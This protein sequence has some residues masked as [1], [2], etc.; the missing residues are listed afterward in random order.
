MY[1]KA[2]I[3]PWYVTR[4][5]VDRVA[6]HLRRV[7]RE[8]LRRARFDEARD[9]AADVGDP[10]RL[11]L[12]VRAVHHVVDLGDEQ[13]GGADEREV[14]LARLD[15]RVAGLVGVELGVVDVDDE[16]PAGDAAVRIDV[17]RRALHR[18]GGALEDARD[19]GV[20]VVG[21]HADADLGRRDPDLGGGRLRVRLGRR[22]TDTGHGETDGH[23]HGRGRR[24][25]GLRHDSPLAVLRE[26]Y[27]T[28]P[29]IS[30]PASGSADELRHVGDELVGGPL[31]DADALH[32]SRRR[33]REVGAVVLEREVVP[34]REIADPPV[35]DE[36]VLG[37][38]EVREQLGEERLA[39]GFRETDD[40]VG[41]HRVGIDHGNAE[42]TVLTDERALHDGGARRELALAH[43]AIGRSG[44][45]VHVDDRPVVELR[46]QLGGH[47]IEDTDRVGEHGRGSAVGHDEQAY[48]ETARTG[49]C[50]NAKSEWNGSAPSRRMPSGST[51]ETSPCSSD[52]SRAIGPK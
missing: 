4:V 41:V 14:L 46:T 42:Q 12:A 29:D 39:V 21:D 3:E 37:R 7:R 45:V 48:S 33:V 35:E 8:R 18:V 26:R 27:S 36:G 52:P 40:A 19:E 5:L 15:E 28:T 13:R 1:S 23:E 32:R 25:A 22:A 6:L 17:L 30:C 2:P 11:P 47:A 38:V 44:E 49:S 50:V 16:L 31:V 34:H 43:P 51:F 10:G 9:Q 20:V 24:P